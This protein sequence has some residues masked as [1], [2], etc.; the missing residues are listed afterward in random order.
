MR[1]GVIESACEIKKRV[2]LG[3]RCDPGVFSDRFWERG[4][5][6]RRFLPLD[7]NDV[8]VPVNSF[9]REVAESSVAVE[10]HELLEFGSEES[11]TDRLIR[12][13]HAEAG[14]L[15]RSATLADAFELF[16]VEKT[17]DCRVVVE[18]ITDVAFKARDD[19]RIMGA[20][21]STP[22]AEQASKNRSSRICRLGIKPSDEFSELI[23]FVG[24]TLRWLATP[25]RWDGG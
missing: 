19:R 20:A 10:E 12:K 17:G 6:R 3:A 9:G 1:F 14:P 15:E 8:F 2:F 16:V 21:L 24:P 18:A 22:I 25:C 5:F 13:A 23:F 11:T 7:L 4:D